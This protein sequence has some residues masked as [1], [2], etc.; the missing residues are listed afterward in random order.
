MLRSWSSRE[1]CG[2]F[3]SN[4]TGALGVCSDVLINAKKGPALISPVPLW[5]HWQN[6]SSLQHFLDRRTRANHSHFYRVCSADKNMGVLI[7]WF[8]CNSTQCWGHTTFHKVSE[9]RNWCTSIYISTFKRAIVQYKDYWNRGIVVC[10]IRSSFTIVRD[11][12]MTDWLI[13]PLLGGF[14]SI[15]HGQLLC[16]TAFCIFTLIDFKVIKVQSYSS[17]SKV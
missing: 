3:C 4:Q 11:H 2:D 16:S 6:P 17:I 8:I 10:T 15:T 5:S 13:E 9:L 1:D 14:S 12:N 7:S